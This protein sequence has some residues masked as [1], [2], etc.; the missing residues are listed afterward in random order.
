MCKYFV[1]VF[2]DSYSYAPWMRY[3]GRGDIKRLFILV[4]LFI[5]LLFSVV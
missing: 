5:T 4:V 3:N 2:V 1:F